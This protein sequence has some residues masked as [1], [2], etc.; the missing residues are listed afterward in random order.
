MPMRKRTI[1]VAAGFALLLGVS[2]IY[3]WQEKNHPSNSSA[4]VDEELAGLSQGTRFPDATL[5]H[6]NVKA[7]AAISRGDYALGMKIVDALSKVDSMSP[8]QTV[9]FRNMV[10]TMK[11]QMAEA[12]LGGDTNA[13]KA[14]AYFKTTSV[15]GR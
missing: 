9:S 3:H 2:Y 1:R 15:L 14:I 13:E 5:E 6:M 12:A 4:T 10:Q 11:V 8:E 7:R